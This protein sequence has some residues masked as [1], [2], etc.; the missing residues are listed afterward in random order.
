MQ[1]LNIQEIAQI[2]PHRYPMLLVDRILDLKEGQFARGM[3]NVSF[4]EHYVSHDLTKAPVFPRPLMIETMAQVGAVALLAKDEFAGKTA[5][6]GGIQEAEFFGDAKP[7]DQ[8]IVE[9]TLTKIKRNIGV[10]QGI[11]KVD[12]KEIAKAELTFM[13]G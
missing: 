2:L 8:M 9:T 3:H 11:V 10:G 5:Y 12:D 6:F 1:T 7:G 4:S 13:I